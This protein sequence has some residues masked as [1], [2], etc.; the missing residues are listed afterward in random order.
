MARRKSTA[1]ATKTALLTTN[2]DLIENKTVET[3]PTETVY[4]MGEFE[5]TPYKDR[6][7]SAVYYG[8]REMY[9][10]VCKKSDPEF[11]WEAFNAKFEQCFGKVEDRKY[12]LEELGEFTNVYFNKSIEDVVQYNRRSLNRR[13]QQNTEKPKLKTSAKQEI[14]Y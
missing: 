2:T 10:Q 7:Y 4:N 5:I 3:E 9:G 1:T 11:D 6:E 8:I 14:P 12:S 13:K